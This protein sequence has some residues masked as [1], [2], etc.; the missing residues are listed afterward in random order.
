MEIPVEAPED[1][2]IIEIKTNEGASISEGDVLATM[3]EE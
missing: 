2:S 1:G 3:E